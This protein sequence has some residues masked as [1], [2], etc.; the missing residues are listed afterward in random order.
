MLKAVLPATTIVC[1]VIGVAVNSKSLPQFAFELS[2]VFISVAVYYNTIYKL[3]VVPCAL[4]SSATVDCQFTFA[5]FFIV[6][7]LAGVLSVWTFEVAE[8]FLCI[9]LPLPF[10]VRILKIEVLAVSLLV[11]IHPLSLINDI[12]SQTCSSGFAEESAFAMLFAASELSPILQ[13][14]LSEVI[15]PAAF[16]PLTVPGPVVTI[17]VGKHILFLFTHIP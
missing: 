16:Y 10:I 5:M 3:I 11:S 2:L 8:T 17:S 15:N 4:E 13:I 14:L 1:F 9:I 6:A 12:F 7:P